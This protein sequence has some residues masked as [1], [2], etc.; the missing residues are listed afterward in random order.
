M[1]KG[2]FGSGRGPVRM[3]LGMV[4]IVGMIGTAGVAAS[5]QPVPPILGRGPITVQAGAGADAG[6]MVQTARQRGQIRVIVGLAD[7]AVPEGQL[8]VAAIGAQRA[9]L[10]S[11]Q[12]AV[13]AGLRQ[14][15]VTRFES[16]P[17]MVVDTDAGGLESLLADS[18]VA[19]VQEDVAVPLALTQSVP[20]I[21]ADQAAARGF[22]GKGQV[23]AILDTGVAK[24]H[25]ML[26][27]KVVAEACYSTTNK[28]EAATSLCP[29]GVQSSTAA[30]SGKNCTIFDCEHGTHVASIAAGNAS[31]LKGVARDAKIISIQIYSNIGGSPG[32]YFSD[33]IAGLERVY[34]LRKK[35]KIASANLSLGSSELYSSACDGKLPAVKA[36]IDNLRSARIA[37]V[38]ASGN[39][40]ADNGISAPACISSAIA[41]GST[42]KKDKVSDFSN[43]S[44][45]VDLMAP[46]SDIY[47]A[48]PGGYQR[49]NGT[50]MATP[51][52]A[53][54]WAILRQAKPKATVAEIQ[55]ALECTGVKVSRAGVAKR[56]IDVLAA[57]DVLRSPATGCK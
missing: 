50:S 30:G 26:K 47:A 29:G 25:P 18:R 9:R 6:A 11:A 17:F 19:T 54:A 52:V 1:R 34:Q 22:G 33:I 16:I 53:G 7:P 49:M 43:H 13:A 55:A 24:N 51:H 5:A 8:S 41:V 46:G 3:L 21:K 48:V 14:S 38:I 45:L 32:A 15:A 42:T 2:D 12:T 35:Y 4:A 44:K 37:T 57:L 27:G 20:L 23:V 31:S 10:A 36:I 56:R 39:S 28:K 40:Y